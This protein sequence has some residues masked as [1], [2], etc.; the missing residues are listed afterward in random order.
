MFI[1]EMNHFSGSLWTGI[2]LQKPRDVPNLFPGILYCH[3]FMQ[4]VY[5]EHFSNRFM[6][7][8]DPINFWKDTAA[9]SMALGEFGDDATLA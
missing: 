1:E 9:Q 2:V 4:N 6:S 8:N 5:I 7:E 3:K